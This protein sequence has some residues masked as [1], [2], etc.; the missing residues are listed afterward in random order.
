M[1]YSQQ[2]NE[3]DDVEECLLEDEKEDEFFLSRS[4]E[5]DSTRSRQRHYW[6]I[7]VLQGVIF[8]ISLTLFVLSRVGEPSDA[9]CTRKLFAYCS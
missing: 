5:P 4:N 1:R 7:W 9:A 6:W 2:A 3:P 8:L